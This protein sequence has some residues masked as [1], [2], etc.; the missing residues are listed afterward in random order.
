MSKFVWLPATA[1]ALVLARP[2]LAEQ[3]SGRYLTHTYHSSFSGFRYRPFSFQIEG[4]PTF[5]QG[6]TARHDV[7]GGYNLGLGVTWRPTSR[8]PLA[9]RV[10]GMY[11]HFD[12]RQAVLAQA[13]STFGAIGWGRT[14][15]WG[16]DVDLELDTL[17]SPRVRLY[18]LVGGGYYD[19]RDSFYRTGLVNGIF[20]GWYFCFEG[21]AEVGL[22]VG[23]QT[24]GMRFEENAGVGLE[25]ALSRTTSFFVDTRYMRFTHDGQNLD[26]V[27]LRFGLRF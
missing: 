18:F 14:Q 11:E 13:G 16:G 10:D 4:G 17:L 26:F 5:T 27:P 23:D 12:D 2:A 24:T 19:R 22:R 20:C 9:L 15:M 21:P 7:A 6:V 1:A 25:F 3:G 8:L